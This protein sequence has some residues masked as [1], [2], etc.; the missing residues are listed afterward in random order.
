MTGNWSVWRC[1]PTA[2]YGLPTA[3]CDQ[4]WALGTSAECPTRGIPSR[5]RTKGEKEGALGTQGDGSFNRSR[6][7]VA[8]GW[9]VNVNKHLTQAFPNRTLQV[10]KGVRKRNRLIKNWW[11]IEVP[12]L[13]HKTARH[14]CH[15]KD[16]LCPAGKLGRVAPQLGGQS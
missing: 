12:A 8:T 1:G 13:K 2:V 11:R 9:K 16:T 4:Q 5:D 6:A 3:V 10:I 14:R 15:L 7:R